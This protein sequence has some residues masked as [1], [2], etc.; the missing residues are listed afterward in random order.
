MA[1]IRWNPI[2]DPWSEMKR[3][4]DEM[5]RLFRSYFG[6][7]RH[8]WSTGLFPAINLLTDEKSVMVRCEMPGVNMDKID[9]STTRDSLTIKGERELPQSG[10]EMSYHRRERRGGYFNRTI[11]LPFEVDPEKAQASYKNGVLEVRIERAA[12]AMPRQITVKT[13]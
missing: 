8:R 13:A 2:R 4:Q 1:I 5:D 12:K 3:V 10:A 6:E 9:L 11:N 7:E